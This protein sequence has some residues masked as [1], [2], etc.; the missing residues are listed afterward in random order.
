M[1]IDGR[2][3]LLVCGGN[4]GRFFVFDT[5]SG[6]QIAR[7]TVQTTPTL[8]NDVFVVGDHAYITD[9]ARPVI[10]RVEVGEEIAA[11]EREREVEPS[12]TR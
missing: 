5:E 10:W 7:R 12:P 1:A 6:E 4:T 2:E 8:L 9:S 3:R 11:P